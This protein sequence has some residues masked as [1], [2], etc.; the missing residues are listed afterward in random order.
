MHKGVLKQG[1]VYSTRESRNNMKRLLPATLT[2]AICLILLMSLVLP[3]CKA[4]GGL[5]EIHLV[6]GTVLLHIHLEPPF[7]DFLS[8]MPETG[9][10][11]WKIFLEEDVFNG[12]LGI[13]IIGI[14]ISTLEPQLLIL[15]G[16]AEVEEVS[17]ILSEYS[18]CEIKELENRIDLLIAGSPRA[19][20]ASKDGWTAL[21]IGQAPEVVMN[22]WLEMDREFSLAA[23]SALMCISGNTNS[24][25][26]LVSE[27]LLNFV[28]V[29]PV[30]R[31]VDWWSYVEDML[32]VVQP[33]AIFIGMDFKPA[34]C[35]EIRIAK[36][37]GEISSLYLEVQDSML[38]ATLP[39]LLHMCFSGE[40]SF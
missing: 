1:K 14:D 35:L 32:A 36:R 10:L 21:Y 33:N 16:S 7:P 12:P 11:D 24:I 13:S 17:S 25:S 39:V 30:N 23:D 26:I 4:Q 37:S 15:T 38:Q 28:S 27:N 8:T 6:P 34:L 40:F 9:I 3:G 19:S 29:M 22:R 31:W 5:R 2:S 18:G 20:I